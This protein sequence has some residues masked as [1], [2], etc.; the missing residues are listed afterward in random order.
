MFFVL[1]PQK[2]YAVLSCLI[3]KQGSLT[4]SRQYSNYQLISGNW[5]PA[6]ILIEQFETGTNRSLTRDLWDITSVDT[7]APQSYEFEVNYKTDALIEHF[8]FD[9]R[10]SE[11]YRYSQ[12]TDTTMLLADRLTYAANGGTQKQNC[13]TAALKYVSTQLGKNIDDQQLAQLV[14]DSNGQTSLYAMKQFAQNQGLY[15]HAVKTDIKSLKNINGCKAILYIPGKKHFVV[16]DAIDD[17][18]VWMVDISN[19]NFYYHT[20]I[21]YFDMDWT[22]GIALLISNSSIAGEFTEINDSEL[23]TIVGLGYACTKL[24]Q[25]Y[26]V[27]YCDYIAGDCGGWYEEHYTRYGCQSGSGSCSTSTMIRYAETPCILDPY[28]L[29]DCAGTGEWTCYYMRACA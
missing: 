23:Q 15:C 9:S 7:N 11:M 2:N 8:A 26:W 19:N 16:L 18:Y 21:N 22:N 4:T 20:D 10:K 14:S 3:N 12:T 17:K 24:L 29:I 6:T 5:I 28:Y 1:D 27:V 13:A 25:D